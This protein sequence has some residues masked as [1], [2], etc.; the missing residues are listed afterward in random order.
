MHLLFFDSLIRYTISFDKGFSTI[1]G[2]VCTEVKRPSLTVIDSRLGQAR[3][4]AYCTVFGS[5]V[6]I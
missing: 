5:V 1:L 4:I 3:D 6:D 2:T